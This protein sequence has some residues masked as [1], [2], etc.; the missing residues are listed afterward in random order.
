MIFLM[1]EQAEVGR[2]VG[3]VT[4]WRDEQLSRSVNKVSNYTE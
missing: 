4:D 1:I 2:L 3:E